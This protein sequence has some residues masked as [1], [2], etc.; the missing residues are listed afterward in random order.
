V[1]QVHVGL[2]GFG[3]SGQVFHAPVIRSV[4]G[5]KLAKVVSS[6]PEKV[7]AA[8]PEA[9]AVASVEELLRDEQIELVVVA[10]PNTLHY[11][12]AKQALEAGKHVVV[13]KPFVIS[14]SAS[15]DRITNGFSTTTCLPASSACLAY[16]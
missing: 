8:L 15:E 2:I 11:P 7:R 3:L 12:Y 13:E 6:H 16:G 14:S 4:P 1:K 9:Q 5:L 10:A